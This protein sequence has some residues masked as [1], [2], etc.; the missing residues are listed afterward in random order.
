MKKNISRL[1]SCLQAIRRKTK[2]TAITPYDVYL[3]ICGLAKYNHGE[4]KYICLNDFYPGKRKRRKGYTIFDFDHVD[5]A[6]TR[7]LLLSLEQFETVLIFKKPSGNGVNWIVKNNSRLDHTQFY[8][9]VSRCLQLNYNL[10][11]DPCGRF[12]ERCCLLPY[13]PAVYINPKY[14]EK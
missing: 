5:I 12:P 8:K 9:A 7:E 11:T 14:V 10:T 13:D 1:F 3:Y 4:T 6:A 2:P